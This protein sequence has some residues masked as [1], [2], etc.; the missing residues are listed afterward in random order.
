MSCKRKAILKETTGKKAAAVCTGDIWKNEIW[1]EKL[2]TNL[3]IDQNCTAHYPEHTTPFLNIV[4][5][6]L[7]C[8]M[9]FLIRTERLKV[10]V[11]GGAD[12][13]SIIKE[14]LLE[15]AKD[16]RL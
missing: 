4:V 6:A 5:P 14:N 13:R 10:K 16:L 2:K 3:E 11:D 1:S 12:Y 9:L 15:A 8:G 7:L